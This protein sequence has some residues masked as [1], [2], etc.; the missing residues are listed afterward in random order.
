MTAK[1]SMRRRPA[2]W[3]ALGFGLG[4]SLGRTVDI[5]LEPVAVGCAM[6]WLCAGLML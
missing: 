6:A 3:T 5:A 4:I 2:L 1:A